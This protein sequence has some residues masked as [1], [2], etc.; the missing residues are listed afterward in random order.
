MVSKDLMIPSRNKVQFIKTVSK[1]IIFLIAVHVRRC[2]LFWSPQYNSNM[3]I[4]EQ[5]QQRAI[6]MRKALEHERGAWSQENCSA[7]SSEGSGGSHQRV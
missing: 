3:G 6:E 4:E 7:G 2:V 5:G 1:S